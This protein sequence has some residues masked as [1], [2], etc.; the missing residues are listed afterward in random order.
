MII[1]TYLDSEQQ[2]SPSE[3]VARFLRLLD[4]VAEISA[5]WTARCPAHDDLVNSLSI[6]E[7]ADGR[8][9]LYCHAGC[10]FEDV[11]AALGIT[12]RCLFVQRRK[13]RW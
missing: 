3:P 6:A 10:A 9:L 1:N 12:I 8:V 2:T 11:V 5:G 7:G 4:N 13:A